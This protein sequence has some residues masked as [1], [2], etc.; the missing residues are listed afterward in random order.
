MVLLSDTGKESA[1]KL[2][3]KQRLS[4][5]IGT[6]KGISK[7]SFE[8]SARTYP[9]MRNRNKDDSKFVLNSNRFKSFTWPTPFNNPWEL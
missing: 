1:T 2:E 5:A 4:I 9:R 3:F 6:A 8:I 7:E